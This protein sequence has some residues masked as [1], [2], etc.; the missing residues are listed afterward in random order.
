ML[1]ENEVFLIFKEN[2]CALSPVASLFL[3]VAP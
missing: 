2:S 3:T 1:L